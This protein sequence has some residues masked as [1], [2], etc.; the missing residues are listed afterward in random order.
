MDK[1]V[2]R[3]GGLSGI[4][5]FIVWII[6]MPVYGYVDPFI[7]GGLERFPTVK[8]VLV[9]STV[10]C[11]V[12]ALLSI[13]FIVVLS[14]VIRNTN[15]TLSLYGTILSIIG[16]VGVALSD[17]ST[18]YAFDPL[19]VLYHS[20]TATAQTKETV[21][22]L[23]ESTQGITY[24]YTF[25][26]SLFLMIGFVALG[27]VMRKDSAIGSRLGWTTIVLGVAGGLGVVFS[28]IVFESIGFMFIADL[29]FL[30]LNGRKL[31]QLS[32]QE[33]VA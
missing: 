17:A 29:L 13:A 5:A 30:L 3:W 11:M 23:W 32:K 27:L 16:L 22:L 15:P 26:G 10:L 19:S 21:V 20:A 25:V 4:F 24:T 18:F 8:G 33:P 9:I 28:L 7:A 6:E 14:K 31:Y 12:T 2:L 1:Q